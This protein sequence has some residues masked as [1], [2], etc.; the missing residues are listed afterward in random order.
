MFDL[1]LFGLDFVTEAIY[2]SVCSCVFGSV[3]RELLVCHTPESPNHCCGHLMFYSIILS[4]VTNSKT[5]CFDVCTI[6]STWFSHCLRCCSLTA[7]SLYPSSICLLCNGCTSPP[8]TAW[9][10]HGCRLSL[11]LPLRL[12]L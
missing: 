8:R 10:Q 9:L 2:S 6:A 5:L 3:C 12:G 4:F 7:R 1:S 11:W